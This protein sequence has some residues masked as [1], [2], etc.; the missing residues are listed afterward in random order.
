MADSEKKGKRTFELEN[1][2]IIDEEDLKRRAKKLGLQT[3]EESFAGKFEKMLD[4]FSRVDPDE[5]L[6]AL[7]E[8]AKDD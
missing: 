7:N 3:E 2:I 4:S 1:G 8:I 6:A 5:L